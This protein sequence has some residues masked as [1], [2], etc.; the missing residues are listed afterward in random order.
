MSS[1]GSFSKYSAYLIGDLLSIAQSEIYTLI[2]I[3]VCVII[4]WILIFNKLLLVSINQ[5]LAESRGV[6]SLPVEMLFTG[7][8]AVI[9][10][11]SIGWVGLLIINSLLVLPAAAAKNVTSN[12]RQF[13]LI[14]VIIA[15]LSGCCGLIM[16]YYWGTATG[17]TIVLVSGG[18]YLVSL[19][20]KKFAD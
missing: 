7:T 13:T 16:S 12:V 14:S 20:F 5:S 17:A 4:L 18:I 19:A 3:F 6:K 11:I 10:T 9:V 15:L 8:I 2:L 1:K